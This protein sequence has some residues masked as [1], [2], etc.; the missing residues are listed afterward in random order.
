MEKVVVANKSG[1]VEYGAKCFIDSTGDADVAALAGVEFSLGANQRDIEE[2]GG[3][4]K[5]GDLQE[6]GT[7]SSDLEMKWLDSLLVRIYWSRG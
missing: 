6:C 2:S 3:K 7:M 4:M 5:M 1:F